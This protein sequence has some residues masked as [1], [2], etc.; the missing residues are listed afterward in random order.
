MVLIKTPSQSVGP[1]RL[2]NPIE[3]TIEVKTKGKGIINDDG[4]EDE[5]DPGSPPIRRATTVPLPNV[6]GF[7]PSSLDKYDGTTDVEN[8]LVQAKLYLALYRDSFSEEEHK[9]LVVSQ[10]L[11]GDAFA[12]LQPVLENHLDPDQDES[13]ESKHVFSKYENFEREMRMMF[14]NP[15]GRGDA[16]KETSFNAVTTEK[17][18]KDMAKVKCY[19]C[20]KMGHMVRTCRAPK[21]KTQPKVPKSGKPESKMAGAVILGTLTAEKV[22]NEITSL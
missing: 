10:H 11:R 6:K 18:K 8:W 9:V 2:S 12:W 17:P 15:L 3:E 5:N 7:R 13:D 21:R 16:R 22:S 14:S 20:N 4:N 1:S 19:N